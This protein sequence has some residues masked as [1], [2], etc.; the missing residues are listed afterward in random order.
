MCAGD[1]IINKLLL[2]QPAK[3]SAAAK[4]SHTGCGKSAIVNGSETLTR[5]IEDTCVL[6]RQTIFRRARTP[7]INET[8]T[9][10]SVDFGRVRISAVSRS[11]A[12]TSRR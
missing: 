2:R 7:A 10:L 8:V 4:L 12:V 11:I 3:I 6:D 5:F 9:S 1:F